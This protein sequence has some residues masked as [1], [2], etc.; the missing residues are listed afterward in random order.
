MPWGLSWSAILSSG[1]KL[2]ATDAV[3]PDAFNQQ[4]SE[5]RAEAVRAYLADRFGLVPDPLV[6]RGYGEARPLT[7]NDRRSG[8]A[9]NRRVEFTVLNPEAVP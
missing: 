7:S 2:G 9:L 3:G 8:R 5:V 6:A 4:L 1:S